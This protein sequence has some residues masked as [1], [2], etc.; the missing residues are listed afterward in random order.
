MTP[1]TPFAAAPAVSFPTLAE[2]RSVVA[3]LEFEA[4]EHYAG[5]VQVKLDSQGAFSATVGGQGDLAFSESGFL[6]LMSTLGMPGP[7]VKKASNDLLL[8]CVSKMIESYERKPLTVITRG[9][10]I[11]GAKRAGLRWYAPEEVLG[12][13]EEAF[14][15]RRL[16]TA[17]IDVTNDGVI[18]DAYDTPI[19]KARV[20]G[21]EYDLG[22]R[23]DYGF[24]RTG[25][26]AAGPFSR[27]LA[28]LN[29]ARVVAGG[30]ALR[31]AYTFQRPRKE[32]SPLDVFGRFH[33]NYTSPAQFAVVLTALHEGIVGKQLLDEEYLELSNALIK[34]IGKEPALAVLMTEPEEHTALVEAT[35]GRLRKNRLGARVQP[36]A[37][38]GG[39][40]EKYG[41]FNRVTAVAKAYKGEVRLGVEEAG[42][43]LLTPTLN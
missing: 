25:L 3:S 18:I 33:S 43:L 27:R 16:E 6:Q 42:G 20:K 24:S 29:I 5:D 4:G 14:R 21:E 28:C 31:H 15:E 17:R 34:L 10:T 38:Q 11:V 13:A 35:R 7:F 12:Q 22:T 37:L 19:T 41:A 1:D 30:D 9:K 23:F 8:T 2:A 39:N 40:F 36:V 26:L 32:D